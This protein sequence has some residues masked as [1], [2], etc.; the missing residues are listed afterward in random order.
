MNRI[1]QL[2]AEYCK[3]HEDALTKLQELGHIQDYL[4]VRCSPLS[5][6]SPFSFY[7]TS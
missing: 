6:S 7:E 2:Y 1:E 4:M 3:R 5:L